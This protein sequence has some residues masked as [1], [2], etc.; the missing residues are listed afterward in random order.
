MSHLNTTSNPVDRV[1]GVYVVLC[2]FKRQLRLEPTDAH[3][4]EVRQ[5]LRVFGGRVLAST[6]AVSNCT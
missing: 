6:C 1:V 3:T 5:L 4:H 2:A